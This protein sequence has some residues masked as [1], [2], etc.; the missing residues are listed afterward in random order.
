VNDVKKRF[1]IDGKIVLI[2]EKLINKNLKIQQ[3]NLKKIK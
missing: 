2:V 1:I 3:K